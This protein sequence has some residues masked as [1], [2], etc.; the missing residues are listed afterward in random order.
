MPEAFPPPHGPETFLS[1]PASSFLPEASAPTKTVRRG[2]APKAKKESN[3]EQ[4][5]FSLAQAGESPLALP[6]EP[7]P[8]LKRFP[9]SRK[10][11]P[12]PTALPS[13]SPPS[14]IPTL[15]STAAESSPQPGSQA[16]QAVVQETPAR[17]LDTP[18]Q[19]NPESPHPQRP[20][21]QRDYREQPREGHS[22]FRQS[23]HT[24]FQRHPRD[25][26]Q[27]HSKPDRQEQ[28]PQHY[29]RPQHSHNLSQKDFNKKTFSQR[30]HPEQAQGQNFKKSFSKDQPSSK[31]NDKNGLRLGRLPFKESLK[32][33]ET[34]DYAVR[35]TFNPELDPLDF[36]A[37]YNCTLLQLIEELKSQG[38]G[39]NPLASRKSLLDAWLAKAFEEKRPLKVSGLLDIV[40]TQGD[41]VLVYAK[42]NY[43]TQALNTFVPQA[44]IKAFMLKKGQEV[45]VLAT[46][47][48]EDH[49]C[50]VALD[51]LSVMGQDPAQNLQ[52]IPFTELVP[53]YPLER[54]FLETHNDERW[55]NLS[56]RT[57]DL[58]TPIGFG[59]RG[60]I[61]APPRTGKTVLL[62]AMANAIAKNY[63]K[64]HLLILLVD[65]RPEEVT[66]FKRHTPG[67]VIYS[68]FDADAQSHVHVAEMV[69][70]K[71]RALV[72]IGKDVVILLDSITRLARAY[73]SM[74]PSTGK[75]L[76]G[77]IESNALQG[78]KRLFGSARNI[79]DG[80]SLT[81][82]GTAL[83]ETGSKM[84]EVI[85]EEFKGTGNMELHLDRGLSD[86]R[87][88]PAISF[89]RS[90]TRKEELL[91]HKDELAKI[92]I[93][94][95]SMKGLPS[96]EA[97][98]MFIQKV[99][100]TP[101]N[102]SFLVSLK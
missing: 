94:R 38:L 59:Q 61:V 11:K 50:L 12:H 96:N 37:L 75:I 36:N 58:L 47:P 81:I 45:E 60:L 15:T 16:P 71:A 29:A 89:E 64:A 7:K 69:I 88:F 40:N 24:P 13:D 57:L 99:S 31:G 85:F 95:R 93:I 18:Q 49:S 28:R 1:A 101:N 17:I 83:V 21:F 102:A 72:E 30:P 55:D 10:A 23:S 68:T 46:A 74:V 34:L 22:H 80:G 91:Y 70:E 79:E 67:E 62:Q 25:Q 97:M 63:P 56:M 2:R 76:S 86:K 19:P 35:N 84:D 92:R 66:D 78:P 48:S 53:Y 27:R 39:S 87:I 32:S 8:S 73:N 6:A 52:R 26:G 9:L 43:H 5:I 14:P 100:K 98:E 77:G 4:A 44:F 54:I 65:E 42:D 20:R 82:I 90:G 33:I 3:S 41:G 51:I